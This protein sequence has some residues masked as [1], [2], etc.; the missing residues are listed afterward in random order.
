[1]GVGPILTALYLGNSTNHTKSV[2]ILY[3][4]NCIR[5]NKRSTKS[6]FKKRT[7]LFFTPLGLLFLS[8]TS[9]QQQQQKTS[10][11]FLE[12]HLMNIHMKFSS[13]WSFGFREEG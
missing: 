1:M 6:T 9:D 13:N 7:T 4:D 10:T 2:R 3:K 11:F 12:D 8:C 5:K